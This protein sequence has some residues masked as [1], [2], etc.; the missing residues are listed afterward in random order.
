MNCETVDWEWKMERR[1]NSKPAIKTSIPRHPISKKEKI[2][3][4]TE[5]SLPERPGPLLQP[6]ELEARHVHLQMMQLIK[7]RL[8]LDQMNKMTQRMRICCQCAWV[9]SS[10]VEV[11]LSQTLPARSQRSSCFPNQMWKNNIY[12]TDTA[13]INM[14]TVHKPQSTYYRWVLK[15]KLI[16]WRMIIIQLSS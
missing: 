8:S 9:S 3:R 1:E 7:S 10:F 4:G 15:G 5:T 13:I 6:R 12:D 11:V 2:F 14:A 16:P